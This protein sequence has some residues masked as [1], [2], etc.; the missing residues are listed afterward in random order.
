MAVNQ[1]QE[2][3]VV[4]LV[5]IQRKGDLGRLLFTTVTELDKSRPA[6]SPMQGIDSY[7]IKASGERLFFRR[8]L[9]SKK[10]AIN[11]YRSLGKGQ[12]HTP[13]P[14]NKDQRDEKLDGVPFHVP[15]LL[16]D[17]PW[18]KLG[19]PITE[20]LFSRPGNYTSNPAP[21][22]GSVPGRLH[23]RFHFGKPVGLNAF[24]D[25]AGALEF[26]ARRMHVNLLEY[27]EYLSSAAFIAPDPI[28][29]QIDCFL[30]PSTETSGERIVYRILPHPGQSLTG[31]RITA[32]DKEAQ[33][34][35]SFDTY[36]VPSDGILEVAK[37]TCLGEYGFVVTHS[38]L[39][40]LAYQPSSSFIRE[41]NVNIRMH[42]GN[43]HRV[44]AP[45]GNSP[46][47]STIEYEGSTGSNLVSQIAMGKVDNP[48][49]A[50][51]QAEAVKNRKIRAE[52]RHYGQRWFPEDSRVEAMQFVHDLL[53]AARSRIIIAD[54][55][56]G[57]LQL[58]Q[59]LFAV[60]GSEVSVTLLTT[61]LAFKG[62][63]ATNKQTMLKAFKDSLDNLKKY[64]QLTPAVRVIPAAS[65]HDRFL[66]VDDNVWFVGNSLNSL[67]EKASMMVRLPDP[68]EVI[69]RL[70][71]LSSQAPT[72]ETYLSNISQQTTGREEE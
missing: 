71:E 37:G 54:P 29:R 17:Q 41:A 39:G 20:E 30:A 2:W 56:L 67:G 50:A 31:L 63:P 1:R 14:T 27:Q 70:K 32:F 45:I 34:L 60:H 49:P 48:S 69:E 28:I 68:S 13:I 25:N 21:F 44:R 5:T 38:K 59:F 11:W 53:R 7:P 43:R 52:G 3:A 35:T 64:Q 12:S 40:V 65:L 62:T 16:E 51:Q 22:I 4:R 8:T 18:P 26:V 55:Y 47:A 6:P 36:P 15:A 61:K 66:V 33:L 9:L 42:P 19:L 72:L 10:D 23:R 46:N 24:L 57:T 58:G